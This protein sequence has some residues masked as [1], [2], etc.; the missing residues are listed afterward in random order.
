MME[1]FLQDYLE[2]V[3][4]GFI[5]SNKICFYFLV[6]LNDLIFLVGEVIQEI[7][8]REMVVYFYESWIRRGFDML[9]LILVLQIRE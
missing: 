8:Q 4:F 1:R 2:R 3:L 9:S 6:E 5:L 7:E